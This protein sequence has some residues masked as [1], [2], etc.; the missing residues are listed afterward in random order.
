MRQM[1]QRAGGTFARG[2]RRGGASAAI[3]P[4]M[5]NRSPIRRYVLLRHPAA[6]AHD[7]RWSLARIGAGPREDGRPPVAS[8]RPPARP[9]G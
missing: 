6:E 4:A 1:E 8:P 9:R 3:I 2:P 7:A 5:H